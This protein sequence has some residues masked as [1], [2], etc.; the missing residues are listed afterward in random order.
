MR[1]VSEEATLK[2]RIQ[3]LNLLTDLPTPLHPHTR[4]KWLI[5]TR[6]RG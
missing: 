2:E 1:G 4:P 6:T 5:R 3:A